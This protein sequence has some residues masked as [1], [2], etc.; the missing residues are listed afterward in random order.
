[1]RDSVFL[2][3]ALG[4]ALLAASATADI[5]AWTP[6]DEPGTPEHA[7]RDFLIALRNGDADA[8]LALFDD[9]P[10]LGTEWEPEVRANRARLED[11]GT[12]EPLGFVYDIPR[13]AAADRTVPDLGR[14]EVVICEAGLSYPDG[15]GGWSALELNVFYL[16]RFGET[17]KVTLWKAKNP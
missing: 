13:R 17:W 5:R 3:A 12:G 15:A 6:A 14:D 8:A 11:L 9:A 2:K 10:W 16:M 4:V 1:M 7:V